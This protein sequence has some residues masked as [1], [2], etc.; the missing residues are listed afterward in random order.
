MLIVAVGLLVMRR[1]AIFVYFIGFVLNWI[2]TFSLYPVD[3]ALRLSSPPYF[4]AG[5]IAGMLTP[6]IVISIIAR[7]YWKTMK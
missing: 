7:I 4:F 1:W 5:F 6:P 2:I 3:Q